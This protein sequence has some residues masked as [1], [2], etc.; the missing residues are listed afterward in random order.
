[1]GNRKKNRAVREMGITQKC[2]VDH[3]S[4]FSGYLIRP[5]NL[6]SLDNSKCAKF[7]RAGSMG[8]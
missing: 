1:M 6:Q 5:F 4:G 8:K 2:F 3:T 7:G